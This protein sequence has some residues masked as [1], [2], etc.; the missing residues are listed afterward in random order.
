VPA[1]NSATENYYLCYGT[2]TFQTAFN[3]DS[4]FD[5]TLWGGVAEASSS[6]QQSGP[7][8]MLN[9]IVLPNQT[10]YVFTYDSYLSLTKIGLP[11]GG[12][13]SYTWQNVPF[14][15]MT[16]PVSRALETRTVNPGNGQPSETWNYYWNVSMTNQTEGSQNL[17]VV[18]Y[19]LWNVE[20]D[21]AG[22]DTEYELGG[23]LAAFDPY[24]PTLVY[25]AYYSGCG[26]H[27]NASAKTCSPGSGVLLKSESYGSFVEV[28]SASADPGTPSSGDS[29]FKPTV[30]TTNWAT[31]SAGPVTNQTVDSFTPGYG[32]C[33][34]WTNLGGST[35]PQQ[36]GQYAITG[37]YTTGQLQSRAYYD[38][39]SGSPGSLLKTESTNYEWQTAPAYLSAN[40]LTLVGSKSTT[41][42]SGV[43]AANVT[44]GYDE[45]NGSP[46]GT[47]GNQTSVT[48]WLNTGAS[49]ETQTIFNKTGM[50]AKK[51]DPIDTAC[52][53]PTVYTYDGTQL[54][55]SSIQYPTTGSSTA[56]IETFSYDKNTGLL[57]WHKDQNLQKTSYSYDSLRRI[58]GVSYPD[59][60]GV[61]YQYSDVAPT[62]SYTLN[63]AINASQNYTET[64]IFD[65][66]GRKTSAQVT[67]DPAG[68]DT[69]D[70]VY[71]SMGRVASVSNPYRSTTEATYGITSF[72][73]DALGRKISQTQPDNRWIAGVCNGSCSPSRNTSVLTWSYSGNSVMFTDEVGNQWE[74]SSD[75]LGRLWQVLE[76]SST[77]QAPTIETDYF[78]N[79]LDD[80]KSIKQNGVSGES[81]RSRSFTYDSLS[82]LITATNPETGTIC[83]GVWSGTSC[84]N[85]YDLNG[86]LANKTDARNVSVNYQYDALNRL[87]QKQGPGINYL[88]SYDNSGGT[89]GTNALGR[90]TSASNN[91]NA[92]EV[93]SYDS[94]GRVVQ[95]NYWT[96]LSPNN[97]SLVAKAVYD[98]A[99]NLTSL[100]YPDGRAISQ[101]FDGAGHASFVNY[102]TWEGTAVDS[103]YLSAASYDAAGHLVSGTM[104][105]GVIETAGFSKRLWNTSLAYS[106]QTSPLWSKTFL[107]YE[108]G[109]LASASNGITGIVRNYT[110][111]NLNRIISAQDLAGT[112]GNTGE[113]TATDG[114]EDT[115]VLEDSQTVGAVGW[116]AANATL[117]AGSAVAP[118]GSMTAG[119]MT[120]TATQ[121]YAVDNVQYPSLYDGEAVTASVWLRVPSGTLAT[122]IYI[123][124]VGDQGYGVVGETAVT[125]PP[126]GSRSKSPESLRTDLRSW[127]YSSS[128]N[129]RFR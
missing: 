64:D 108:N 77:S 12:S 76:P 29:I 39:G 28:D 126:A 18:S 116:G 96:P 69:V 6:N 59:G 58:L 104:G 17:A 63:K 84:N 37:C 128:D 36:P 124:D 43:Q 122:S 103:P 101:S 10:S 75:G 117:A 92:D 70:T 26:P 7:V 68:T 129:R 48:D 56:H 87:T 95:E 78:Y 118:D 44:Y 102:E 54:F 5:T 121:S 35:N 41:D 55:P 50:P 33:E 40:L 107:W 114:A 74:R 98:L 4:V 32:T 94:M 86:N 72:K 83:Y 73:Y 119:V 53:N 82:R 100:T 21:P 30:V 66:L 127:N 3:L 120:A 51:C 110:Y 25:A 38:F 1:V 79:A 88:Y 2:H 115:N 112:S 90:L 34:K 105:N 93:Y 16:T 22:N 14:G 85:G 20:T 81:L 13:I 49:P 24:I 19:P 99:G 42:G 23:P 80:L 111:D 47:F 15:G 89:T 11:T 109:N 46:Q 61:S 8:T 97:T 125:L 45:N 67:S 113:T 60:G 123:I 106:T 91:V 52:K 31:T 57:N 9:A 62:P 27:D 65:G 71:D